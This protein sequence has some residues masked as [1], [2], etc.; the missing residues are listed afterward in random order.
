MISIKKAKTV[1]PS[2]CHSCY[3]KAE[4]SN[5][6]SSQVALNQLAANRF[7][8]VIS[9]DSLE[10]ISSFLRPTGDQRVRDAEGS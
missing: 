1:N 7:Y 3:L 6:E 4:L 8:H 5:K 9:Y 10:P 2:N